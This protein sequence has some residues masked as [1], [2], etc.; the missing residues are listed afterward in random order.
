MLSEHDL[1]VAHESD[2]ERAAGMLDGD[3]ERYLANA[4][5]LRLLGMLRA[6]RF[7]QFWGPALV[8]LIAWVAVVALSAISRARA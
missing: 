8:A 5:E 2:K 3:R 4:R 1:R 6:V 7:W